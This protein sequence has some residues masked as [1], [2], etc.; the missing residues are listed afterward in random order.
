MTPK[1]EI[2]KKPSLETHPLYGYNVCKGHSKWKGL[3][4]HEA[5][6][7]VN[8][9]GGMNKSKFKITWGEEL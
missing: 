6:L 7:A 5:V 1:C 8:N 9:N 2:C 4:I 3:K